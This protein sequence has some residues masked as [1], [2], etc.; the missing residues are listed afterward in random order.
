MVSP[1]STPQPQTFSRCGNYFH[2]SVSL[3]FTGGVKNGGRQLRGWAVLVIYG[4][5]LL[6]LKWTNSDPKVG[7]DAVKCRLWITVAL[8]SCEFCETKLSPEADLHHA[9]ASKGPQLAALL[10]DSVAL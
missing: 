8:H 6:I 9:D 1:P 4:V 5:N 7:V 2:S 10:S 3:A